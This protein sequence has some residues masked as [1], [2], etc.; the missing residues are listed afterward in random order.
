MSALRSR[1]RGLCRRLTIRNSACFG[2]IVETGVFFSE[3]LVF[4]RPV[5]G[6]VGVDL[7]AASCYNI[8][9]EFYFIKFC[10]CRRP[11]LRTVAVLTASQKCPCKQAF[12]LHGIIETRHNIRRNLHVILLRPREWRSASF[13][14]VS[15]NFGLGAACAARTMRGFDVSGFAG[16]RLNFFCAGSGS[17]VIVLPPV[18]YLLLE[19][20]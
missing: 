19:V 13:S 3:M 20:R 4:M 15:P 14:D 18:Q 12:L 10:G 9:K 1:Q 5:V 2:I 8:C 16:R 11:V 7:P 17:K 6:K